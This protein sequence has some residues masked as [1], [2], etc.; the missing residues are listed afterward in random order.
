MRNIGFLIN[1]ISGMGGSVGLKGT[2]GL[3]EKALELGAEKVSEKRAE[4]FFESLGLVKDTTFLVPSGEMGEDLLKKTGNNYEVIYNSNIL[5]S[6]IDTIETLK[7][8]KKR[9][10]EIVIF[11]G[12]DGTARDIC[13]VIGTEIPVIGMPAGVK[14]FSSVFAINPK[15]AS[16]L[17]KAFLEGKSKYKDSDVLDIDEESYRAD[18]FKMKLYGYLKTPYVPNLIQDAKAVFEGQD[19]EMAKE[20]IAV[21]ASEFMSDG[22]LYI[23]GAGSTTAKIAE[24]MGLKKTMLGVDLIKDEK[25]I[26][27]DVNENAILEHIKNEKSV[28]L[29]VSPIGAQGFVFGRGNQQISSRVLRKVGKENIIIIATPQKLENTPF[30]LVDTGDEELDKELSGKTLVVCAYRMAQRKDIRKD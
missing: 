17:L 15:A 28:K 6:R 24:V 5:T 14:M 18:K 9:R 19:E 22:S 23:V 1:P 26:A 20:G 11:C 10:V 8:F 29:I 3:Y 21:F 12:G 30:L 27:S 13:E 16:D 2:D 25:L 7:E 4:V